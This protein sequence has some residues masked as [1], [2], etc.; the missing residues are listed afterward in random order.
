MGGRTICD[1]LVEFSNRTLPWL[2]VLRAR[3]RRGG[4]ESPGSVALVEFLEADRGGLRAL[5]RGVGENTDFVGVPAPVLEGDC[6]VVGAR[7]GDRLEVSSLRVG[8]EGFRRAL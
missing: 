6:I 7:A 5:V 3:V 8:L 4:T 1:F 2:D